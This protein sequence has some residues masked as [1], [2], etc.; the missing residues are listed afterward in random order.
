MDAARH[1]ARGDPGEDASDGDDEWREELKG[2]GVAPGEIE[3]A[4]DGRGDAD[5][6]AEA[7]A[8]EIWPENAGTLEIFLSLRTQWSV[9]AGMGGIH[10]QGFRYADVVADLRE[11]RIKHRA[12]VYEDLKLMEAAALEVL[13][14]K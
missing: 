2:L 4:L 8:F 5:A 11:R 9:V 14:R 13:N 1:W 3:R 6:G 12:R 10:I 7:D